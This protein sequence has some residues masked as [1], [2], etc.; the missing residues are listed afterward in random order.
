MFDIGKREGEIL[1]QKLFGVKPVSSI[2]CTPKKT[3]ENACP[4]M[5]EEIRCIINER[6]KYFLAYRCENIRKSESRTDQIK[7]IFNTITNL[8]F[9][10]CSQL[11]YDIDKKSYTLDTGEYIIDPNKKYWIM[12]DYLN[13]SEYPTALDAISS[14]LCNILRIEEKIGNQSSKRYF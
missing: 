4:E 12:L 6:R 10:I 9:E 1:V 14:M 13:I 11:E 8:K 5:T 3:T 7:S 2:K